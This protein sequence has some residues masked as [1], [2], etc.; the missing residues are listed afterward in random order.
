MLA[1]F[2]YNMQSLSDLR[3]AKAEPVCFVS[4]SHQSLVKDWRF[5]HNQKKA[6]GL[7]PCPAPTYVKNM[8]TGLLN[9]KAA[10]GQAEKN[11][12]PETIANFGHKMAV[13]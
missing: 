7:T 10:H 4:V 3:A 13:I 12:F 2:I 1:L 8:W 6:A 9:W 11:L 5:K